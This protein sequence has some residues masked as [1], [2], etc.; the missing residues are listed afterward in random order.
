MPPAADPGRT[1][2]LALFDAALAAVNGRCRM[3]QTL[4]GCAHG[5]VWVLAVGKAASAMTLGALDALGPA[6][7]RAL[8]VSREGHFDPELATWGGVRCMA[9]GHP[10][11]DADSL[12]AGAAALAMARQAA[13]GQRV[14]LLVSGGASS[15]LE[16]LPAGVSLQDL[17]DLNGWASACGLPIGSLNALRRSLS[18]VKD[19]RLLAAFAHCRSEG[20]F[21]SDVPH[22]DPAVVASG[23]L[24]VAPAAPLPAPLPA[25]LPPLLARAPPP[26]TPA[27]GVP[28]SCVGNLAQALE[29]VRE[30]AAAAGLPVTVHGA[31][32]EGD[33]EAAAESVCRAIRPGR[34][35]VQVFG[36][37]T[38]V[39]LPARPGRGGR[40]QHLALC[41]ALRLD[42]D[43]QALLLAC[44][45]DGT[46]GNSDDAGALVDGGT[47]R[48][49]RDG[50]CDPLA[51]LAA[52]D[53]GRFLEASGDLVHTG[54]TGTNVGDLL[55]AWRSDLPHSWRGPG[56]G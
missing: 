25:W 37:E 21:I 42:G 20:Y 18:C 13:A 17:R 35:G 32:L 8:V 51:S 1:S 56:R 41:A 53:S 27:A 28:V 30:A 52:A 23:L 54:P 34:A 22:D 50:G 2:L 9:A 5:D 49:G 29:A 11:P 12:A 16:A 3:R 46:D 44:G 55:L 39:R 7:S 24:A 6:V 45:T 26:A 19:G 10:L 31:R 48:R 38:T 33:A 43:G 4:A 47:L 14:L 15:L 40:N 36:G